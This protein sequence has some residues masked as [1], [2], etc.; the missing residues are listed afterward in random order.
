MYFQCFDAK[1][2]DSFRL[3]SRLSFLHL[4]IPSLYPYPSAHLICLRGLEKRTDCT[5]PECLDLHASEI[6]P[7]PTHGM[8][9]TLCLKSASDWVRY[10]VIYYQIEQEAWIFNI[11]I[12]MY[13]IC[14]FVLKCLTNFP[15]SKNSFIIFSPFHS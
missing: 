13:Y 12:K 4:S 8:G 10:E 7:R 11:N 9:P 3:C 6:K 14:I 1:M 2:S 5:L 15:P